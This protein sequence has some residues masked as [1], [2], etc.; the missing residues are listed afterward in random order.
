MDKSLQILVENLRL[1][2]QKKEII[3]AILP[4]AITN[5]EIQGGLL[6]VACNYASP[7]KASASSYF[8]HQE[9]ASKL[10]KGSQV[11]CRRSTLLISPKLSGGVAATGSNESPTESTSPTYIARRG[12]QSKDRTKEGNSCSPNIQERLFFSRGLDY[13]FKDQ[14]N[15]DKPT[16]SISNWVGIRFL[17]S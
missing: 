9:S 10:L 7:S 14:A 1:I 2:R 16:S 12:R 4:R 13:H 6:Q 15:P 5:G 8:R 11:G 3:S 17:A